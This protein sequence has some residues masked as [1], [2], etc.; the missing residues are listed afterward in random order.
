MKHPVQQPAPDIKTLAALRESGWQSQT[1]KAEIRKNFL[2]KLAAGEELFPGIV[3][4]EYTVLPE[5]NIALLAGHDMLFLG[6]KGQAKSRIMRSLVRFLDEW[7]PY[8]NDPAIPFH[9]DPYAPISKA[10]R[11]L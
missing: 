9:D 5:I 4:Y 1:V 7:I 2:H 10:G 6:E 3:G 11:K 8:L